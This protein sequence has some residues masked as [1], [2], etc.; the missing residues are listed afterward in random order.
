VG[1]RYG[2]DLGFAP[3]FPA[4]VSVTAS[5]YPA[6][7]PARVKTVSCAG[8]ATVAGTFG[9]A[10][11][12]APL[13][14][15]EPGEYFAHILARYTDRAGHLWVSTMRHAGVVYPP[16]SPIVATG[17]KLTIGGKYEDRGATKFE[18][19]VHD[20]GDQHLAHIAF[21]YRQGDVLLIAS[22]GQG[23][24]KIEPTLNWEWKESPQ[25]YE[26]W[27]QN[28]GASNVRMVTANGYS[29]HLFPEFITGYH[30][31]YASA[32][33]PGFMGRFLV[34]E[35]GTR[36]PYWPTSPNSFGGQINAS[37]NGDLPGDIYRL[38]GGVVLR[39]GGEKPLYAGYMASAFILPGKSENNRVVAPGAEDLPGPFGQQARFFLVGLRPGMTYT[40]GATFTPG[41]Q[42]DPMLPARI[43]FTLD[44][45]DGRRVTASGLGDAAGS[46]AGKER[47]L[48]DV[49][50][51]Y[52]YRI[53]GEWEGFRG[54]MPGLP[55]EGGAFYVVEPE[56][57]AGVPELQ[58]DLAPEV[59]MDAVT[60]T[61]VQGRSSAEKVFFAAVCPGAVLDQGWL[62]VKDG[63]WSYALNPTRLAQKTATYDTVNRVSGRP[64]IGDVI[65]L[66]FFSREQSADGASGHSFARV[67]VRG[68]RMITVR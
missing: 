37:A 39:N 64:E 25:K 58:L 23:A 16:D 67:V 6:S 5:L 34:Q 50:G 68:T 13:L 52:R 41:L 51:V 18:G 43:T 62:E 57:V 10:Q 65:H 20:N 60:G 4:E 7:D 54:G 42:I 28:I 24:N 30:Y 17:K 9:A 32:P 14:F 44:Y 12:M 38:L 22:E 61:L 27:Y 19:H 2:R 33:R 40:V 66:T 35:D 56:R 3:A 59:T 15:D 46:F 26:S 47:W 53:E 11:G 63:K 31:Y 36:A 55:A 8:R 48:L 45:P 29:P 21:P 1:G 49:P